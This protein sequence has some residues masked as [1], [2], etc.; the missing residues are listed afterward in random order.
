MCILDIPKCIYIYLTNVVMHHR[1]MNFVYS[2]R[3]NITL[4]I[5]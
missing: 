2:N 1:V 3:Q 5:F 4:V